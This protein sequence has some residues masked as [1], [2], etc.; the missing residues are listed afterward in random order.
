MYKH[1]RYRPIAADPADYP[2]YANISEFF[3]RRLEERE[4]RLEPM[5]S[6]LSVEIPL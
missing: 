3:E 4:K 1:W 6:T 2:F 5:S